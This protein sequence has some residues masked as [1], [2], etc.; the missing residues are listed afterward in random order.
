MFSHLTET[1]EGRVFLH[2]IGEGAVLMVVERDGINTSLILHPQEALALGRA[3]F[4]E[5]GP[6]RMAARRQYVDAEA[7]EVEAPP[8]KA[9]PRPTRT[10]TKTKTKTKRRGRARTRTDEWYQEVAR[11]YMSDEAGASGARVKYTM[12]M[13]GES[14]HTIRNAVMRARDM[15][16]IPDG[17]RA[18]DRGRAVKPRPEDANGAPAEPVAL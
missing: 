7:E 3:L 5:L 4:I 9:L 10:K 14:F 6:S 12:A 13:T 8:T 17:W 18:G 15:H 1:S 11:F 2:D 16:Y